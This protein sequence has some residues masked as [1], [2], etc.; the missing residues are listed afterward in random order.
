MILH[1]DSVSLPLRNATASVDGLTFF[2][3]NHGLTWSA[4]DSVAVKI[5]RPRTP[6]AYG[7][8]TI[9]NALM[10]AEVNPNDAGT[11]GFFS[12]LYGKLTNNLIVNGRTDRGV[13]DD[14]FRYPW[15]GYEIKG[16]YA[17]GQTGFFLEFY[18]NSYPTA[19]EVAGWT[20]VLPGGKEL[21]FPD[22][23]VHN[24]LPH[25]W[26]FDYDPGWTGEEQVSVSI[27]TE[28][29]QNRY[30]QVLLSARRSTTVDGEGN[31]VYGKT[32][33]TYPR[34]PGAAGISSA[35]GDGK[36]GPGVS[37]ELLRLNVITDKTGDTDPVWITATFRAPN[38][39]DAWTGY[40]EGQFDD[41]HTLFLRWIYHEGGVGKGA[42][43]YTLPL[44]AAAT[45]GGIQ[46]SR[47]GRDVSF[48]WVRTYKEFQRRHLDLANHSDIFADMLAPPPPATAR[49][50]R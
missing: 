2:W 19:D 33:S 42:V 21:P 31:I 9:W 4:D 27:R 12:E 34:Q 48:T 1:L 39:S 29:V 5:S 45:E 38:Q 15:S 14:Q 44:R 40:W 41:F 18:S 6:N 23:P 17:I 30:G 11:I 35:R 43:T 37:W 22:A 46:R 50:R 3:T 8:R 7:F 13:V 10:T 24:A 49:S 25:K 36:F 20:L 47:S 16:L 26:E 32:H 28:D